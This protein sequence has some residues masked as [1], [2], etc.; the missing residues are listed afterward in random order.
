[1]IANDNEAP[2]PP[3][4]FTDKAVTRVFKQID[5][6]EAKLEAHR[7]RLT[8]VRF[9]LARE[10]IDPSDFDIAKRRLGWIAADLRKI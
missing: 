1:M 10:E 4:K 9:E 6:L 5:R 3:L 2:R 8:S 7:D